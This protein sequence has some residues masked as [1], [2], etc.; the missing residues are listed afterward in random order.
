MAFGLSLKEKIKI[1]A[2][3]SEPE[4]ERQASR[5][6]EHLERFVHGIDLDDGDESPLQ[7]GADIWEQTG[8][9]G[10]FVCPHRNVGNGKIFFP[11]ADDGLHGISEIRKDIELQ[12]RL[13]GISAE[14]AGGVRDLGSRKLTH[15]PTTGFLQKNF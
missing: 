1:T 3:D 15:C 14:A 6:C 11:G 5:Q 8:F 10:L 7:I 9:A 4:S 2:S 13:P 12:S